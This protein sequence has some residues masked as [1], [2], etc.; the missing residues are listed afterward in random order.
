MPGGHRD[1]TETTQELLELHAWCEEE[2][3]RLFMEQ[4]FEESRERFRA[5]LMV[6][7]PPQ[8]HCHP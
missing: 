3:M 8:G 5:E 7:D 1:P 2:A 6:G 4:A